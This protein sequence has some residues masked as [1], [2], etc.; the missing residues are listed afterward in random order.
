MDLFLAAFWELTTCRP[1]GMTLA[2][3]PW[4]AIRE[5]AKA[6]SFDEEQTDDLHYFI[7]VMDNAYMDDREKVWHRQSASA[8]SRKG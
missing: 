1:G 8:S 2:P 5:Y 3:I 6:S 4:L 7:R